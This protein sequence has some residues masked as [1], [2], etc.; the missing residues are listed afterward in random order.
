VLAGVWITG[1]LHTTEFLFP[2]DDDECSTSSN[3]AGTKE[4]QPQLPAPHITGAK[5]GY[6]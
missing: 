4:S 2:K 6:N 3:S 1:L 5:V